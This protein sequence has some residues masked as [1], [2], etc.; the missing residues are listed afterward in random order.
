MSHRVTSF[1]FN[2]MQDPMY[3]GST[4]C[5]AGAALWAGKPA[6]LVLSGLVYVV[7]QVA[8]AFEG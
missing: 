6:G 2:I 7:Y 5:F 4:M 8:L 3:N 1:P